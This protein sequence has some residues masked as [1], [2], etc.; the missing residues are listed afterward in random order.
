MPLLQ[1]TRDTPS[2]SCTTC[3]FCRRLSTSLFPSV[4]HV[5]SSEGLDTPNPFYTTCLF[6]RRLS[7]SLV[8]SCT[9]CQFCRRIST[10]LHSLCLPYHAPFL[11]KCPVEGSRHLHIPHPSRVIRLFSRRVSTFII[12]TIPRVS[13][14][15]VFLTTTSLIPLVLCISYAEGSRLL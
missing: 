10:S 6:C 1:K 4:P 13:S 14:E 8:P 9:T 11:D 12:P 3:L 15:N 5:S 2:P 7:T